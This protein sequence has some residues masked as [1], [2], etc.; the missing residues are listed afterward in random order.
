MKKNEKSS[1]IFLDDNDDP[2]DIRKDNVFKAVFTKNSPASNGA[3]SKLVSALIGREVTVLDIL[4][5]E[6]PIDSLQDRQIRYDINCK[7]KNGELICVE[8]SLHPTP[9]ELARMVYLKRAISEADDKQGK[10]Q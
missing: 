9:F 2:I 4:A 6:P 8:M 7:A 5:N 1:G 10:T 3:L